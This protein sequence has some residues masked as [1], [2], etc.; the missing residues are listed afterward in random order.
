[1]NKKTENPEKAMMFATPHKGSRVRDIGIYAI[2]ILLVV[3]EVHMLHRI[4][5]IRSFV[6]QRDSQMQAN[7]QN[8]FKKKLATENVTQTAAL[9]SATKRIELR[10]LYMESRTRSAQSYA[11]QA[12]RRIE[13]MQSAEDAALLSMRQMLAQKASTSQMEALNHVVAGTRADVDLAGARIV[14]LQTR[15]A[16]LDRVTADQIA[17]INQQL[18]AVHRHAPRF[19]PF[20]LVRNHPETVGGVAMVLTRTRVK[21]GRF[22]LRLAAGNVRLERKNAMAGEP[23]FFVP[24]N[25]QATYEVVVSR[26]SR[27]EVQGFLGF[28]GQTR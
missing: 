10:L 2:L 9:E 26:I 16:R 19:L 24:N 4:D 11:H 6:D 23:I 17:D 3:G 27:D 8:E 5:E 14:K 25:P 21:H 18:A 13:Q 1:M 15:V 7:L 28:P 20:R 12:A 22:D